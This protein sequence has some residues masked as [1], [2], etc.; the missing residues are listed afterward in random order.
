MY[1]GNKY[2]YMFMITNHVKSRQI[3]ALAQPGSAI[4]QLL[5]YSTHSQYTYHQCQPLYHTCNNVLIIT[6]PLTRLILI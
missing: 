6:S 5:K 3:M 2:C 4:A 1:G